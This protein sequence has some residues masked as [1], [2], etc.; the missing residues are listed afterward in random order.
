MPRP[1]GETQLK[2]TTLELMLL[3]ANSRVV[4]SVNLTIAAAGIIEDTTLSLTSAELVTIKAGTGLSFLDGTVR[5]HVL[6]IEDASVSGTV[7]VQ[8][9]PLTE[10]LSAGAV[11][12]LISGLEPLFGIQE[13]SYQTQPQEVDTTNLQSGIGMESA[14]V[15]SD[16]TWDVSGIQIPGDRAL[17]NIVKKVAEDDAFFGREVYFN[18]TTP[19]GEVR[20]AAAKIKNYSESG[21]NQNEVKKYSFQLQAQGASFVRL[22]PF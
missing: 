7:Q 3:P 15:R 2:N 4:S 20:R 6:I 11:A 13:F 19:D 1:T 10:T 16:K 14:L 18:C 17:G 5:K 12:P 9:S 8:I 22:S 21:G